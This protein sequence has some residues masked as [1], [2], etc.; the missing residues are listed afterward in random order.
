MA[1]IEVL[2]Q[3]NGR[4]YF[5]PN[6]P[7]RLLQGKGYPY[8]RMGGVIDAI[9]ESAKNNLVRWDKVRKETFR[10]ENRENVGKVFRII[11]DT[12]YFYTC[13]PK[14]DKETVVYRL[15]S[16]D[17][18]SPWTIRK[19]PGMGE[20]IHVFKENEAYMIIDKELNYAIDKV[21]K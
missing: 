2:I 16:V 1:Y 3:I 8:N 13:N 5:P 18:S 20:H 17:T 10:G 4:P 14:K 12:E 7:V 11:G 19:Y 9:R 15:C 6:V 21:D